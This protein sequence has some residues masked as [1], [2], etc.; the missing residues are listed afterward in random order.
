[1]LLARARADK[2]YLCTYDNSVNSEITYENVTHNPNVSANQC[3]TVPNTGSPELD[4]VVIPGTEYPLENSPI[5]YDLESPVIVEETS[6]DT[7]TQVFEETTDYRKTATADCPVG[8]NAC[9]VLLGVWPDE[10]RTTEMIPEPYCSNEIS[11]STEIIP[12]SNCSEE[13]PNP[14]AIVPE[15]SCSEEI[16]N[17]IIPEPNCSD[18]LPNIQQISAPTC[19]DEI[20]DEI[21]ASPQEVSNVIGIHAPLGTPHQDITTWH[22]QILSDCR[23]E[24]IWQFSTTDESSTNVDFPE[25][26]GDITDNNFS[27]HSLLKHNQDNHMH[28]PDQVAHTI[29]P[30]SPF[31]QQDLDTVDKSIVSDTNPTERSLATEQPDLPGFGTLNQDVETPPALTDDTNSPWISS[32]TAMVNRSSSPSIWYT[33]PQTPSYEIPG[34]NAMRPSVSFPPGSLYVIGSILTR[35]S[36]MLVD[37]GASV[38]AVS[39]SFFSSLPS[40][41]QLQQSNLLTIRTVSGEELPAQGQTTLTLTLDIVPYVLEVLVIDNLTYP[42]VLGRDFLMKYGSII[43]MQAYTLVLSGNPPIPLHHSPGPLDTASETPESTT[44]HAKATFIL[45]PLSESVIPVYPKTPL[46]AGSTGLIEPSSHL[47]E[48]YHV[49]GAFNMLT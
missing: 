23:H 17:S 4:I 32:E 43:D 19:T 1:M 33:P 27:L 10:E 2:Q 28:N 7:H 13:I 44:V 30:S 24:S 20:T 42:V 36:Q 49:C 5:E 8:E 35:T 46:P 25:H 41:P 11:N 29:Y 15:P 26:H 47:A 6:L 18:D 48:R 3:V 16:P 45:A 38:T 31:S 9:S 39:S 40:N 12:E 22:Q 34:I 37:T 21:T 14:N